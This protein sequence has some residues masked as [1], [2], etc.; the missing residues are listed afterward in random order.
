VLF[1][2]AL[3]DLV[4]AE[5]ALRAVRE[6]HAG[7]E[8]VLAVQGWL[9]ALATTAGLADATASLDDADAAGVFGG[10]RGPAWLGV[11]PRL[12]AWIG[13]RDPEVGARLRSLAGRAALLPVVRGDGAEH[14]S[15]EYLRQVGAPLD[16]APMP[17]WPLPEPTPHVHALGERPL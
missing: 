6:R 4:L 15:V 13:T 12:Y 1:P 3:G 8:L 16:V 11:R 2:G 9:R 10:G 14:A 5:P 17:R 7:A